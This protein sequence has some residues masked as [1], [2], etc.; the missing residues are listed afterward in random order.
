MNGRLRTAVLVVV[1]LRP[2]AAHAFSPMEIGG[3]FLQ[4]LLQPASKPVHALSLLALGLLLGRHRA[5]WQFLLVFAAALAGGL[6]AIALAIGATPAADILLTNAAL[7][8]LLVASQ[9]VLPKFVGWLMAAMTGVAIGLDS[10]PTAT[11]IAAGNATLVGSGLGSCVVL[12]I[13]AAAALL[14][15]YDWQRIALR[16][17]GSWIAASAIL[18]LA[19]RFAA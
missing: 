10:P 18:V 4:G 11:S 15:R 17:V 8:G 5:W 13:A 9:S 7:A 12:A 1:L 3:A 16:I 19:L 2:D 6:I 14:V